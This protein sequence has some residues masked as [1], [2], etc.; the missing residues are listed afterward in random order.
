MQLEMHSDN[1]PI[2]HVGVQGRINL[3]LLAEQSE[4]LADLLP[5]R[6]YNRTVLLDM[7]GVE[8]ID[9]AGMS[10]LVVQHKRFCDGGG[11]M[12]IHSVP[13]TVLETMKVMRLD[14]VLNVAEDEPRARQL[15]EGGTG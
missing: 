3:A 11:N 9:S 6:S 5:D 10:W 14:Q 7:T 8:L 12:A 2:L 13:F 1:G 15:V 4:A